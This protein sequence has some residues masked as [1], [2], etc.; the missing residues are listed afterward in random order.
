[1]KNKIKYQII[2]NV[3]VHAT[4]SRM[5]YVYMRN[6]FI[7]LFLSS[8]RIDIVRLRL[9][10][11]QHDYHISTRLDMKCNLF[12]EHATAIE[13]A[14]VPTSAPFFFQNNTQYHLY[15]IAFPE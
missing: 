4:Y 7:F 14:A 15:H 10:A 1:M 8:V 2:V 9:G 5:I 13:L 3:R 11:D 12:R 6:R